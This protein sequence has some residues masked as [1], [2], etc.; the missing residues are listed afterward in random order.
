MLPTPDIVAEQADLAGLV[1]SHREDF[2]ASYAHT[3]R[4]WRVRFLAAWPR[5]APLG[6]DQR[7]KRMWEYYLAYCEAGFRDG[8]IDVHLFQLRRP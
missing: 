8:A 1:L 5:I 7:F 2:G 3:L 6:F 4:D